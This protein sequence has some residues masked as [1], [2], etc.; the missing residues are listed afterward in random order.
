M[1]QACSFL[2]FE[3]KEAMGFK[4]FQVL[5]PYCKSGHS[6]TTKLDHSVGKKKGLFREIQTAKAISG[7]W[8]WA[9]TKKRGKNLASFYKTDCGGKIPWSCNSLGVE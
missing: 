8:G 5:L 6:E 2:T 3:D 9:E 7:G 4:E 1:I